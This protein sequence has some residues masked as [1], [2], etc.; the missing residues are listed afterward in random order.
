[1]K[2]KTVLVALV[3]VLG[4]QGWATAQLDSFHVSKVGHLSYPTSYLNDVWGY[5]DSLGNEYALV[6]TSMGV[7]I[8]SLTDPSQ[9]T[10]V[11]FLPGD[12]STWRDF[13]TYGPYAYVSTEAQAG[14]RIIDLSQLPS[15]VTFRD[16]VMWGMGS[17]HTVT[18]DEFGYAYVNGPD[19][20]NGG[21][22]I[23]DVHTDPWRPAIVGG[24]DGHYVHDSYVRDNLVYAAGI[25]VSRFSI[26]DVTNK[27]AP[28]VV[29][30][31][32]YPN[33]ATHTCWLDD[34]GDILYTA[35]E[36]HDAYYKA[37]DVSNPTNPIF[38]DEY[39][40]PRNQDMVSPHNQYFLDGFLINSYYELGVTIL[41]V[42]HPSAMVEVGWYDTYPLPISALAGAWAAY[43][44]LPSGLILVS[45]ITEGLFVLQP[46]YVHAA[47]VEGTPTN[48][49]TGSPIVQAQMAIT[50]TT[51]QTVTNA[52]GY[53]AMGLL[54]SAQYQITAAAYGYYP[55]DTTVWMI[56]GQNIIW[57]PQMQ[58]LPVVGLQV[59][60][61]EAVTG[62]P[63]AN[64]LVEVHSGTFRQVYQ[65]NLS[66]DVSDPG[67]FQ[68]TYDFGAWRWGHRQAHL[69]TA[70]DSLNNSLTIVL[71]PGFEDDFAQ[72]LG[73]TAQGNFGE[74]RW[75]RDVPN[76]TPN[77]FSPNACA[78]YH[79]YAA[80]YGDKCYVTGNAGVIMNDDD[81]DSRT[82]ITSPVMD[83]SGWVNPMFRW[84]F[85]FVSI[86][87][88][89]G[90]GYNDSL[91]VY[92]DNGS[93]TELV[94]FRR[95]INSPNWRADSVS[96]GGL[97]QLTSTM[98]LI[99]V[100]NNPVFTGSTV[101]A[102]F[103]AFEAVDLGALQDG[104]GA[105]L[106]TKALEAWPV[107]FSK[108]LYLRYALELPDPAEIVVSDLA[109]R[110]MGTYPLTEISGEI[111]IAAEWPAGVYFAA[112]R[113]AGTQVSVLKVLRN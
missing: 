24:W 101:E 99:V 7:S 64:A 78:P 14:L 10:E 54:D 76:G 68:E 93:T 103:D 13:A 58:P 55:K 80:D 49:I 72:D 56:P 44:Y 29:G 96:I 95:N 77:N 112:L 28:V 85:W 88:N 53:Y 4:L 73:W 21:M 71:Q 106:P 25:S 15:S 109:G 45:D 79:D 27:A 5:V 87:G 39:Q 62:L 42:S 65:T 41:D 11:F 66:G 33:G 8:V 37:W 105:T 40:S 63:I 19:T 74:G 111:E 97:I 1:M 9:P 75:E 98:R 60:V 104:P 86:A 100:A 36:I 69:T 52:S 61:Q 83:L 48:A 23:L 46:E 110:V 82:V 102:G 50:G 16:T 38:L 92:I 59:H 57:S 108:E 84:R 51:E 31:G 70:I 30:A 18:I 6:G 3:L 34:T 20:L 35:D 22:L 12:G 26:I 91:V 90:T 67:I 113:Q 89:G 43:P 81:V 47:F 32:L 107:P 17:A 2:L 94:W